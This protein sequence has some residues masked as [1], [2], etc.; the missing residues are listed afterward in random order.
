MQMSTRRMVGF[1]P[2]SKKK[3]LKHI[4]W[5]SHAEPTS[6]WGTARKNGQIR[7]R[8]PEMMFQRLRTF[9][10]EISEWPLIGVILA[11]LIRFASE[12]KKDSCISHWTPSFTRWDK[13]RVP[14]WCFFWSRNISYLS[15]SQPWG[16]KGS[17][18][19]TP[20]IPGHHSCGVMA[21][22]CFSSRTSGDSRLGTTG[23]TDSPRAWNS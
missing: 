7:S 15:G 17:W 3:S 12:A 22:G 23:R 11:G 8:V 14:S 9:L 13:K 4:M 20:R 5:K 21:S 19:T 1:H 6:P 16:P 18:T 10:T 2:P